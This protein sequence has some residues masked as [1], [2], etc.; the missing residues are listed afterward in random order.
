MS[1]MRR[2]VL[3]A[4]LVILAAVAALGV[5]GDTLQSKQPSVQR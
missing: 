4:V 2:V 1:M 3:S 5:Y